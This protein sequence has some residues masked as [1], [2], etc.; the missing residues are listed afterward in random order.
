M[1]ELDAAALVKPFLIALAVAFVFG[2]SG[3]SRVQPG[4]SVP[5][6]NP[7]RGRALIGLYGCGSCHDIP[8]VK[9]AHG[10]VGPPLEHFD[11]RGFVAGMVPNELEGLVEFIREPQKVAPGGAMPDMEVSERDAHDIAAYLYSLR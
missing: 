4:H 11:Q 3:D 5:G 6:G 10:T 1:T 7:D 8:G 2:C 9:G